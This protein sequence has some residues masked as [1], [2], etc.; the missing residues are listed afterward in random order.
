MHCIANLSSVSI[1][2]HILASEAWCIFVNCCCTSYLC[3]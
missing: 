3:L 2:L 1:D